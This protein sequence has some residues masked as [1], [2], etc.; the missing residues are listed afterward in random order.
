M[1]TTV[2]SATTTPVAIGANRGGPDQPTLREDTWWVEPVVTVVILTAFVVYSTW[3]AF[4]G[5]NYYAGAGLH[6]NYISPFYSPCIANSC[7]PGSHTFGTLALLELLAGAADP[8][9]PARLPPHLLL[10]PQGLLPVLLVVAA[11]LRGRRRVTAATAARRGSRSSC[12]T[13]T[14]TSSGS[15]SSS[16]ASSPTTPS[17]SFRPAGHRHRHRR[18]HGRSLRQRRVPVALQPFVPR[19]PALLRRPGALLRQAPDPLQ[20]LEVRDARS[21]PTTCASPGSASSASPSRD[22]YVRLVA[23]G[24]IHD[25]AF[26]FG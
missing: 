19:L 13:S 17:S 5:K 3:A 16:T 25:P 12:R 8:D 14:A 22:L 23:S 21:T 18:R 15:S 10:L 4:V 7:V 24:T 6:R 2:E 1:T 11:G 20:A 9:L 26:H